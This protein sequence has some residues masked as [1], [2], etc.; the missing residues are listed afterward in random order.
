MEW[1]GEDAR[2]RDHGPFDDQRCVGDSCDEALRVR[3]ELGECRRCGDPGVHVDAHCSALPRWIPV[4]TKGWD[5][6][7]TFSLRYREVRNE[8][9][10]VVN[11][12]PRSSGTIEQPRARSVG[13]GASRLAISFAGH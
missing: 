1:R 5:P 12:W 13:H 2:C 11:V 9:I 7:I 10:E 6:K 8:P 3:Q 4:A